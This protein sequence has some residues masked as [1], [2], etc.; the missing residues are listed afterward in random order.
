MKGNLKTLLQEHFSYDSFQ[1]G[2]EEIIRDVLQGKNVLG[3]LKTGSGKSICYQLPAKVLPHL[4]L[5]VSPLI[6]LMID[7]VREAKAFRSIVVVLIPEIYIIIYM[8]EDN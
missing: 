7:Q 2:Q 5:V 6:S 4:T 3:M 8:Y 1:E